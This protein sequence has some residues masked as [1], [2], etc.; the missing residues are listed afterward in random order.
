MNVSRVTTIAALAGLLGCSGGPTQPTQ[1]TTLWETAGIPSGAY[2]VLNLAGEQGPVSGSAEQFG[3][4]SVPLGTFMV[5]GR[6]TG[7]QFNL[8]LTPRLHF[9]PGAPAGAGGNF[10]GSFTSVDVMVGVWDDGV[11][12]PFT[13]TFYLVPAR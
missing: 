11:R 2:I 7:D 13:E 5:A 12:A 9:P 4:Q 1:L 3:L 10:T 8:A 6:R